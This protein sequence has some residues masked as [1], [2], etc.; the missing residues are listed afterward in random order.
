MTIW[1]ALV[2]FGFANKYYACI[3]LFDNVFQF[4]KFILNTVYIDMTDQNI[5]LEMVP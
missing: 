4:L 2:D 1:I 5:V 3:D